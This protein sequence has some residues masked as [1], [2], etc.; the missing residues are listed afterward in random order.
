ML[1][2]YVP[3]AVKC[4]IFGVEL[5]GLSKDS[6]VTIERLGEVSTFRKAQDGSHTA[7]NDSIGSYRVTFNIEQVSQSNDFLHT[8]FKLHQ[9]SGLNLMIPLSVQESVKNGGTQ[10]TA[11]DVFFETEP[12]SEFSSESLSRQWSFICNSAS[13]SL[14]GTHDTGFLT[15]ALRATIRLIEISEATGYDLTGIENLIGKGIEEA[16]IRLKNLF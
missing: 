4:Y 10:F 9:R 11:F 14:S 1:Y 5:K 15:G 16:E 6:I 7:F 12:T 2:S 13:Y 8:I 3:S